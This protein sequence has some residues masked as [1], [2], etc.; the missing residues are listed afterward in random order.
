L[1]LAAKIGLKLGEDTKHPKEVDVSVEHAEGCSLLSEQ[2][3][4]PHQVTDR[5]RQPVQ[6][7]YRE[8]ITVM[9]E[10]ENGLN[11][12]AALDRHAAAFLRSDNLTTCCA[13]RFLLNLEVL[14]C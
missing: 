10:I 2:F 11:L 7:R 8:H 5:S 3:D 13:E 9:N 6:L 12:V 14:V 1:P 4:D